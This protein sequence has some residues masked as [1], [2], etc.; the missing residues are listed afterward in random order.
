S[1]LM[2]TWARGLGFATVVT[3]AIGVMRATSVSATAAPPRGPPKNQ[4]SPIVVQL[5]SSEGC[6]SCPPAEAFLRT[7]SARGAGTPFVA[8]EYHVDY[9]DYLGWKDAFANHAFTERQEAYARAFGGDRL[10]TPQIVVRGRAPLSS[11]GNGPL[12]G[13]LR[14]EAAEPL[15]HVAVGSAGS[16]VTLPVDGAPP[17]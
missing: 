17:L 14:R 6:S 4:G 8:L 15:A 3:V 2:I 5:F 10:Y 12:V 1:L 16:D 9:W 11:R 7:V 13:A